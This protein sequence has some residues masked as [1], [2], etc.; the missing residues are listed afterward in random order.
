MAAATGSW[1]YAES[2]LFSGRVTPTAQGFSSTHDL[3]YL[4]FADN[5]TN[6]AYLT[7]DL[8]IM[9]RHSTSLAQAINHEVQPA[10][11]DI[12]PAVLSTGLMRRARED[13][14]AFLQDELVATDRDNYSIVRF[15]WDFP[16]S[17]IRSTMISSSRR[18]A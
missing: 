18:G 12:R 6:P 9:I 4:W 2:S 3:K 15:D 1:G 16:L 17:C 8:G 10:Q 7:P 13:T 14:Q 5:K 11:H